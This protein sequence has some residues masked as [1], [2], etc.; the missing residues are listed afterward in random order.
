MEI[1]ILANDE[2]KP[3]FLYEHGLSINIQHQNQNILFDTGYTDIYLKN[4]RK[5]GIHFLDTDYIVL[6]HGHYDHTGGL[7]YFISL[8]NVKEIILHKDAFFPKYA[9]ES[10]LRCNGIPFRQDDLTWARKLY[11]KIEGFYKVDE[12]IYVLGNIQNENPKAKYLVNQ[13]IDDFHD[14]IILILEELDGLSLFLGCSHFGIQN[15]IET[16]KEVLP[17]KHIKNIIA[18]MH[19]NASTEEEIQSVATYFKSLDFEKLIPLH[20]TGK[21][22]ME[23]FKELFQDRCYL[24]KAGDTLHI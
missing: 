19:M 12:S 23:T 24:L 22:A 6:S 15:G 4:A 5:L 2:A 21:N 16:V 9:K 13:E 8:S 11:K 1:T 7:R 10:L 20:C 14:E 17:K 18:G 3:G